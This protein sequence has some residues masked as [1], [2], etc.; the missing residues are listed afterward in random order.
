MSRP[1]TTKRSP[2]HGGRE[3]GARLSAEE[4]AAATREAARAGIS[5]SAWVRRL[6]L[7]GI[8]GGG[9]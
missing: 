8:A 9:E 7:A 3:V 1:P 5:L 4:H 2:A 6:V